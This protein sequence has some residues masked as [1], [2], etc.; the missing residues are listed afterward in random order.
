MLLLF[1]AQNAA[2]PHVDAARKAELAG[3]FR[4]AE[5]EYEQAV[6]I[7]KDAELFQRL[8]LVRHLQNKFQEAIPAFQ[9]SLRLN[10]DAW[11]ARLFLGI[12]YYRTNQFSKALP[13]LNAARRLRP[14]EPEVE[15]WL[16]ATFIALH[17]YFEGQEILEALT[18]KQPQ[19]V[20]AVRILAQSYSDFAVELHNRVVAEHPDSAWAHRIHGQALENEGACEAALAE[21]RKA[22][23]LMPGMKGLREAMS[24]CQAR[25]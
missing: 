5:R 24:R 22:T 18:R 21:Y 4:A 2:E 1:A 16:G 14:G 7:R 6:A 25:H 3:D 19:N 17:R 8:G 11:G 23:E 13:S 20:E 12:D 9:E 15:F 10:P